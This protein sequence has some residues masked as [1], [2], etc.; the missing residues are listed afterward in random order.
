MPGEPLIESLGLDL[1]PALDALEPLGAALTELA[2]EFGTALADAISTVPN[3]QAIPADQ[4]IDG[5]GIADAIVAAVGDTVPPPVPVDADTTILDSAIADVFDQ[6]RPP[7]PVDGDATDLSAAIDDAVSTT[8]TVPVDAD[9]SAAQ[10]ALD[11][12]G[13][14]GL[15]IPV[16]ADT[17]ALTGELDSIAV[18]PIEVSIGADT[19]E[20][21]AA[22][23]D[24][25]A[26]ADGAE[27]GL[28]G[29]TQAAGVVGDITEL[30]SGS[31]HGLA[32]R[33]AEMGGAQAAVVGG[34]VAFTA[35]LGESI[36]LAAD[37]EAVNK[38]F[39]AS[40]GFVADSMQIDV[41]GLHKD[42]K[43]LAEESGTD[44]VALTA[45][46]AKIGE[47]GKSSGESA[48]KIAATAKNILALGAE[49]SVNNPRLGDAAQVS[50]RL[51]TSL[52][53]G[54]RALNQYGISLTTTA[55]R[56]EA[57][58]ETGKTS[59]SQLTQF[60]LSAAGA[61]LAVDQLGGSLG[62]KFEKG[63]QNAQVQL[64]GLKVEIEDMLTAVGGP[65]LEPLVTSLKSVLPIALAT[66]QVLGGVAQ[67]AAPAFAA[68]APAIGLLAKPLGLVAEGLD[69]V[70]TVLGVLPGPLGEVITAVGLA[71]VAYY[72]Y[73]GAIDTATASTIAF[74]A[75]NPEILAAVAVLSTVGAVF[76]AISHSEDEAKKASKDFGESLFGT[77]AGADTLGGQL[78]SLDANLKKTAQDFI[79]NKK[80]GSDLREAL[81]QSGG[82]DAL[83]KALGST[84]SA[85]K[86][87]LDNVRTVALAN[88]A[89][90]FK[91]HELV[92]DLEA[93]RKGL[94]LQ[95]QEQLSALVTTGDLTQAQLDH[96]EAVHKD[97][98]GN[99]N[100]TGTLVAANREAAK[101]A[102]A[103]AADAHVAALAS[104]EYTKLADAIA[105]GDPA[106]ADAASAATKLGITTQDATKFVKDQTDALAADKD[107]KI[108][109]SD[110]AAKLRE[111]VANGTITTAQYEA[112]LLGLDVSMTG[113]SA[114]TARLAAITGK[115]SDKHLLASSTAKT[116]TADFA[117]GR[118]TTEQFAIG[119]DNLGVSSDGAS[120][121]I[122]AA[123]SAVQGFLDAAGSATPDATSAIAAF[124]KSTTAAQGDLDKAIASQ[125]ATIGKVADAN[126]KAYDRIAE[127]HRKGG[128]NVAAAVQNAEDK[129]AE[130][131]AAGKKTLDAANVDV[132]NAQDALNKAINPQALVEGLKKNLT[133]ITNF[134]VNLKKIVAAGGVDLAA[135]FA[136]QGPQ[137]AA[138][139]AAA[140]AG[141]AKS[142]KEAEGLIKKGRGVKSSYIDFLEREFGPEIAAAAQTAEGKAFG[143]VAPNVG[144]GLDI[145]TGVVAQRFKPDFKPGVDAGTRAAATALAGD[146]NISQAAGEIGLR[147]VTNFKGNLPLAFAVQLAL[148][149][150]R[151]AM[152]D[153]NLEN[154]AADA[155]A[156]ATSRYKPDFTTASSAGLRGAENALRLD[157][158]IPQA[159]GDVGARAVAGYEA[160]FGPV[161]VSQATR[162]AMKAATDFLNGDNT[163]ESAVGGVAKRA[164]ERFD[165]SFTHRVPPAMQAAAVALAN[166]HTISQAAGEKGIEAVAAL[167]AGYTPAKAIE[168]AKTAAHEALKNDPTLAVEAAKKGKEGADAFGKGADFKKA[169]SD[170]LTQA[171][172]LIPGLQNVPNV[173]GLLGVQAGE[174]F[175]QGLANGLDEKTAVVAAAAD[176]LAATVTTHVAT[177]H[178]SKSPS[179]V[180][181]RLGQDFAAGLAIG[182]TE[183]EQTVGAASTELADA[184]ITRLQA[185]LDAGLAQAAA[186][187]DA[188]KAVDQIISTAVGQLPTASTAISTTSSD[189]SSAVS[190]QK[191]AFDAYHK[192]YKT[193]ADDK[194]RLHKLEA[195]DGV[196]QRQVQAANASLR[197]AQAKLFTDTAAGNTAALEA[198]QRAIEAAQTRIAGLNDRFKTASDQ[199]RSDQ[200]AIGQA[201]TALSAA[202]KAL[203]T[204]TDP[205]T[206]VKNVKTQN[207]QAKQ[208]LADITTLVKRGDVDLAKQLADQGVDAAGK[209]ARGLASSPAK[210]KQAEAAIDNAAT[211]A[212]RYKSALERLFGTGGDVAKTAATAGETVG[213]TFTTGIDT[214]VNTGTKQAIVRAGATGQAL[215]ASFT[216]A[217]DTSVNTGAKAALDAISSARITVGPK[218]PLRFQPEVGDVDAQIRTAVLAH[219]PIGV[220][221]A[222]KIAA[223]A[224]L[225]V[226]VVPHLGAIPAI[227]PVDVEVTPHLTAV[228]TVAPLDVEVTPHVDAL[229]ALPP[230]DVEVTA[231]LAALPPAD[232]E[233]VPHLAALPLVDVEVEVV[234]HLAALAP[235]DVEV[236]PHVSAVP[237]IAPLDVEVTPHLAE[238]P[239]VDV[240]VTAHLGELPPVDV[241]VTPRLAALPTIALDVDVT[242]HLAP[243]PPA[244]VEVT[245]HLTAVPTIGPIDVEVI[246]HLDA[247]P[248]I[249][250]L[251]V[252]V[253]AHLA[254]FT[255]PPVDV[256]VTP[257]VTAPLTFP[258]IHVEVDTPELAPFA[259]VDVDVAPH[260][261]PFAVAPVDVEVTPH[262][263]QPLTFPPADVDVVAHVEP[264]PPV[265]VEV[266]P[267]VTALPPIDVEV[268]PRLTEQLALPP[269]ELD[270]VP[271]VGALPA[272]EVEVIARLSGPPPLAPIDVEVV[273]H[274]D[275][276]P[277]IDLDVTPRLTAPPTLAPVEMEVVPHVDALPPIDLAVTPRLTGPFELPATDLEVTPR[278]TGPFALPAVDVEVTPHISAL[279]PLDIELLAH[280]D[281]LPTIAPLDVDVTPHLAA[282]PPLDP[283]HVEVIPHLQT[284]PVLA[285][286]VAGPP[287]ASQVASGPSTLALD[288]TIVLENGQTVTAQVEVP[289][290]AGPRPSLRQ[291]VQA[292]VHA[293]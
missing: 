281:A 149:S 121:A 63:A 16:D 79:E 198:D 102:A 166:D 283:I 204:A 133:D 234:P 259:P 203:E 111:E 89:N 49:L 22:L 18:S 131:A 177:T 7:I 236:T 2:A 4:I 261:L 128:K 100:Y 150:A 137:I 175:G 117:A 187:A 31:V 138:G 278:L 6:P 248:T 244:D 112:Q 64:R 86:T 85:F 251:D 161:S 27:S 225:D 68:L 144:R 143:Q 214:T 125:T 170:A 201:A 46:A 267:H 290:P 114:E 271:H 122:S 145:L 250:P 40:F 239:A 67:I 140:F 194:A 14:D 91:T 119:L 156:R 9:T 75:A 134:E 33:V 192:A 235:V 147:A 54:G 232:V 233:V 51:T 70:A 180:A 21:T 148:D 176:R 178:Q 10:A 163:V 101:H 182:V 77:K 92:D 219:G 215:G 1:Q 152:N 94:R 241:E 286:F 284:L 229:P 15:T 266:T 168:V 252:E 126:Q 43:Q 257:H 157:G 26:S 210:A 262:I 48:P 66:G 139:Q 268:T 193:Y 197:T 221:I 62:D 275:A 29:V 59:T 34:G 151:A 280:L 135:E 209:I 57:L 249:G 224:P 30:A 162:I 231:H 35:F 41:G 173:A 95:E 81:D 220:D 23:D 184:V 212:D 98:D 69:A 190:E 242:P 160:K 58:R 141:D 42:L 90:P 60:E 115:L 136:R 199:V 71:A 272:I 123:T 264:L 205:A 120:K 103:V 12:L 269:A 47:L 93:Q 74:L 39:A 279:P 263:S 104:G 208:F 172:Q 19:S 183:G 171:A 106:A 96:L 50:D 13:I 37:A 247:L 289:V 256:E 285:P 245:P 282:L 260:L 169:A 108:L 243:L 276:L 107:A 191:S 32:D 211:F 129:A 223:L 195:A 45:T 227:S 288:L 20:L 202:Q 277:A 105:S 196:F 97:A 61:K 165:P 132:V 226:D 174:A 254:A 293:S 158:T 154:A 113:V 189:I 36:S 222:P 213:T 73:A 38:R 83:A 240:Q 80:A 52:A 116:L 273:P 78:A 55:I 216:N 238:L 228:P 44:I 258:P 127:A 11:G 25:A 110:A 17:S 292:E 159:A 142:T 88:G 109:S 24:V 3:V 185:Q 87:Y 200:A 5:P 65:L 186:A 206:F 179:K 237:T 76:H 8:A 82:A 84:D 188:Q 56:S 118:I 230:A 167:A 146:A 164:Q 270:V 217:L 72:F 155:A 99:T 153:P 246:P 124:E 207:A 130:V 28:S 265:D 274:V 53:R 253:T 181:I 287:V 218:V 291:L 255:V